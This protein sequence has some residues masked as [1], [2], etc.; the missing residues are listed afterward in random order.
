MRQ[1]SN[2]TFEQKLSA[3][4]DYLQSKKSKGAVS[5]RMQC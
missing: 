4:K 1:K 3:V 5:E 2:V